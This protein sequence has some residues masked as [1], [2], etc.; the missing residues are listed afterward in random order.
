[1]S[2]I[3]KVTKRQIIIGAIAVIALGSL[4]FIGELPIAIM[5]PLLVATLLPIFASQDKPASPNARRFTLI[6]IG[7]GVIM[8]A[9]LILVYLSVAGN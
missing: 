5:P 4:W 9:A 2:N 1:M 8:L 3:M 7:V 6:G